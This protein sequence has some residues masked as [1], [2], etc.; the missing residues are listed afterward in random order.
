M[1][2]TKL[3]VLLWDNFAYEGVFASFNRANTHRNT[4]MRTVREIVVEGEIINNEVYVVLE[5]GYDFCWV[6]AEE[7]QAIDVCNHFGYGYKKDR[8]INQPTS[9]QPT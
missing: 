7:R 3:Y 8:I 1:T 6:F 9:N 2:K 5:C 4:D